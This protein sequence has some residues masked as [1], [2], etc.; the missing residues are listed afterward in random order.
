MTET[1]ILAYLAA[2]RY[3][4]RG[5]LIGLSDDSS[6]AIIGYFLMGRSGNSRNRIIVEQDNGLLTRAWD[7]KLVQ[8]PSLIIY[9]P[10]RV[11]GAS[12]PPSG[13]PRATR[14]PQAPPAAPAPA[15]PPESAPPRS[16]HQ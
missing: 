16:A 5:I 6:Q 13:P 11:E 7:E 8:D 1:G 2:N 9:A 4:G 3:A 14:R 10:L 12:P 15:S